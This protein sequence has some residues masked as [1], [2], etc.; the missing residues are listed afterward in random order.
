MS[1]NAKKE[2]NMV[3]TKKLIQNLSEAARIEYTEEEYDSVIKD[4]QEMVNSFE[5]LDEVENIKSL[6]YK[7]LKLDAEN[8]LR[9]DVPVESLPVQSVVDNAPETC[10]GAIVVPAMVE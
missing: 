7:G 9:D 5:I 4:L 8:D 3:I 6:H 2:N 10:G 1:K